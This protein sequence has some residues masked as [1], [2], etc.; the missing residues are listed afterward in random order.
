MASIFQ[1]IE[2]RL[3]SIS[4]TVELKAGMLID[5]GYSMDSNSRKVWM[6]LSVP[7]TGKENTDPNKEMAVHQVQKANTNRLEILKRKDIGN[8]VY[9]FKKWY[10]KELRAN[11]NFY[12]KTGYQAEKYFRPT[13][14]ELSNGTLTIKGGKIVKA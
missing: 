1:E 5:N 2:R 9:D 6:I 10:T 11:Q 3:A 14:M 12:I 4:N 8:V 7:P 13:L